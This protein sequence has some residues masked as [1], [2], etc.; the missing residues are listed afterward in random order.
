M[1]SE[2]HRLTADVPI[3]R[4]V[5]SEG[6]EVRVPAQ[7]ASRP[8]VFVARTIAV[9][10]DSPAETHVS[11]RLETRKRSRELLESRRSRGQIRDI[12]AVQLVKRISE[13]FH[14]GL[15]CRRQIQPVDCRA[16]RQESGPRQSTQFDRNARP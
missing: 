9:A 8:L 15:K 3:L 2:I 14:G 4:P 16:P 1:P 5:P 11:L 10:A 13:T 7:N 12:L 6:S